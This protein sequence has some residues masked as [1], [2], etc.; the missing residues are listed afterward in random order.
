MKQALE[1]GKKRIKMRDDVSDGVESAKQ[2]LH[3]AKKTLRLE[4]EQ[5]ARLKDHFKQEEEG[6][7]QIVSLHQEL[8]SS[9]LSQK[10][11][12]NPQN[13]QETEEYDDEKMLDEAFAQV[14]ELTG[15]QDA[16][17]LVKKLTQMDELNFSRF[18]YITQELEA[19]NDNLEYKIAEAQR[20]LEMLRCSD[21]ALS[22]RK[23]QEL[24]LRKERN[25]QLEQHIK[26]VEDK[27]Q[28]KL[29]EWSTIKASI[30]TACIELKLSL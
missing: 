20:E 19:T 22:V 27:Y 11:D 5:L 29:E 6:Q 4:K 14:K 21:Q 12:P 13:V 2:Q 26:D 23:Q 1:K 7:N 30:E 8:P 16:D 9:A 25:N 24:S 17:E 15:I 10:S 3:D 28:Q 18:N